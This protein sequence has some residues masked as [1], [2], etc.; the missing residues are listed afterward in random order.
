[1]ITLVMQIKALGDENRFR[2]MMMLRKRALCSCEILDVLDIAGGTLSAHIKVL[3]EAGLVRADKQGRWIEYRIADEGVD[4]LMETLESRIVQETTILRDRK[5]I[6]SI[7][8][9]ECSIKTRK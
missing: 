2:I 9:E 5:A 1:M 6:G 4:Q 8:R 7:S 3:K